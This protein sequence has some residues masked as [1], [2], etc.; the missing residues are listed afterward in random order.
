MQ[1]LMTMGTSMAVVII[2]SMSMSMSSIVVP[3]AMLILGA[4]SLHLFRLVILMMNFKW[5][6]LV[7]LQRKV[8]KTTP[9]GKS[10]SQEE[11]AN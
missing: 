8:R 9:W 4:G 3:M 10:P 1:A 11:K 5:V 2:M 7:I 6:F